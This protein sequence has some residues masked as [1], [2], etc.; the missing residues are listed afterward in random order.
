LKEAELNGNL[1]L[2]NKYI[3]TDNTTNDSMFDD[4]TDMDFND[5]IM[6]TDFNNYFKKE[7]KNEDVINLSSNSI[8]EDKENQNTIKNH[9]TL[10]KSDIK[11]LKKVSYNDLDI[12]TQLFDYNCWTFLDFIWIIIKINKYFTTTYCK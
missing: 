5:E 4:E 11:I 8:L 7:L 2:I 10:K 12:R 9:Y 6:N 3:L 1:N